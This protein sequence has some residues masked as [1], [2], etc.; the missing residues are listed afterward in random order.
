MGKNQKTNINRKVRNYMFKK[1]ISAGDTLFFDFEN[2]ETTDSN[3][4]QTNRS[5]PLRNYTIFNDSG[6][7]L[8]YYENN[9]KSGRVAPPNSQI[10]ATD[11]EIYALAIENTSSNNSAS[12]IFTCDN[13][14]SNSE[15]TRNLLI[16]QLK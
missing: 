14:I 6:E 15:L 11:R 13:D 16:E 2:Q 8:I 7:T 1:D 5:I 12:I 3:G 4:L 10:Q 9:N